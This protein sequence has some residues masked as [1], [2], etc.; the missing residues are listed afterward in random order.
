MLCG[1]ITVALVAAFHFSTPNLIGGDDVYFTVRY[2]QLL[3]TVW[4]GQRE[5]LLNPTPQT[6][7]LFHL[8]LVPFTFFTDLLL[9]SKLAGITAVLAIGMVFL[10]ILNRLPALSNVQKG[11][12]YILFLTG[13]ADF[14]YRLLLVRT[15]LFAILFSL[16]FVYALLKRRPWLIFVVSAGYALAYSAAPLVL[17]LAVLW[18]ASEYL[19]TRHLNWRILFAT[20]G[21]L[22]V[23]YV[24]SPIFPVNVVSFFQNVL[25]VFYKVP[26]A[27]VA[28]GVELHAY[29]FSGL[30][31]YNGLALAAG[32]LS[33]GGM[34]ALL[35]RERSK[36]RTE[37]YFFL[38]SS[39]VFFIAACFHRRFV[40]YWLPFALL[41]SASILAAYAREF[42][43]TKLKP[44]FISI[45]Q[46]RAVVFVLVLVAGMGAAV[47][48]RQVSA[49]V[50]S[51]PSIQ[52]YKGAALWLA[53]NS[54]SSDL[55]FD[56]RWEQYF[57]MYFWNPSNP[58][59]IFFDPSM[60]YLRDP[61]LYREWNGIS[62]DEIE[63]LRRSGELRRVVGHFN[64][65][66]L[67]IDEF[68]TPRLAQALL[69]DQN[70]AQGLVLVFR[71]SGLLLF[72]VE[73]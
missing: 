49:Y 37:H 14:L 11:L 57:R 1:I 51:T 29:S 48:L 54:S 17:V 43:W 66:F 71:E 5:F 12:I 10:A 6:G 70:I 56:T 8:F 24:A 44:L 61:N 36:L 41:F 50:K 4:D 72:K 25:P 30:L 2:S 26:Y 73:D 15:L 22:L 47:N 60:L 45:W 21:G 63:P 35:R 69:E 32:A 55:V 9:A 52:R 40:E 20:L 19:T 27:E 18:V 16:L 34:V 31:R 46:F 53:Q 67:L 42:S 59:V 58:Y 65:R 13:S 28:V 68:A 62:Q 33:L 39:I 7:L 23:G 38:G 3:R 64:A